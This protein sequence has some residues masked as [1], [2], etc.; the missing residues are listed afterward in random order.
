MNEWAL[1]DGGEIHTYIYYALAS[2]VHHLC[3]LSSLSLCRLRS[4][5]VVVIFFRQRNSIHSR[6]AWG[7]HSFRNTNLK[8]KERKN[9]INSILFSKVIHS[10]AL[11]VSHQE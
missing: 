6:F 11:S 9:H 8:E 10:Q 2:P 1:P 5:A 7:C 3:N 4:P